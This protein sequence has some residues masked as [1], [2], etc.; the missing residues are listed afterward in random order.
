ML[1]AALFVIETGNKLDISLLKNK[2]N[3]IYLHNGKLFSY[4]K[5]H[6]EFC[7]QMDRT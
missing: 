5:R 7:R 3:M 4:L 1:I 6:H 2:E